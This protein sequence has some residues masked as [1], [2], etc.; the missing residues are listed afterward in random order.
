M[1]EPRLNMNPPGETFFYNATG[2]SFYIKEFSLFATVLM[3]MRSKL[4]FFMYIS[5]PVAAINLF[6]A[7]VVAFTHTGIVHKSSHD[8]LDYLQWNARSVGIPTLHL[9]QLRAA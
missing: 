4:S 3:R 9:S 2:S 8:L 1:D 6:V 7:I 5:F